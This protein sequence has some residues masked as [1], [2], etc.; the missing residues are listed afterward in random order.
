MS[1]RM[2]RGFIL[3]LFFEPDKKLKCW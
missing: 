1:K 2:K 3:F